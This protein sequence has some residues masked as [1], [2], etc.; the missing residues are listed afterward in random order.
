MNFVL[1][2]KEIDTWTKRQKKTFLQ[3]KSFRQEVTNSLSWKVGQT[4]IKLLGK[5]SDRP[6]RLNINGHAHLDIARVHQ[7]IRY[8]FRVPSGF[9]ES[10]SMIFP[11]F[12]MTLSS[13]FHDQRKTMWLIFSHSHFDDPLFPDFTTCNLTSLINENYGVNS[14]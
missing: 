8:F 10:N 14:V 2:E 3:P 5:N 12:S 1:T 11:W 4:Y 7:I 6:D 13:L 9:A